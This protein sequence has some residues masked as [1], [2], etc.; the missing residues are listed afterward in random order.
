MPPV[1][2][3]LQSPSVE[4]DPGVEFV[5]FFCGLSRDEA[6]PVTLA[7]IWDENG[8]QREQYWAAHRACLIK[9][10]SEYTRSFGGPLTAD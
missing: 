7:A 5:C 10:M 4:E 8:R 1:A 9:H 6:D 3:S 2:Y